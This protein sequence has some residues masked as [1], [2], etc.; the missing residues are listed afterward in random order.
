MRTNPNK[1]PQK[2]LCFVLDFVTNVKYGTNAKKEKKPSPISINDNPKSMP[3]KIDSC[4]FFIFSLPHW[5][6]VDGW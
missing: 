2:R 6:V 1:K 4:Q 5:L 3:D